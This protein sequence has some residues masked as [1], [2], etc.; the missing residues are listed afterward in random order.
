M[1]PGAHTPE[2]PFSPHTVEQRAMAFQVPLLEHVET[3]FPS[4][5][6]SL[7]AQMPVQAPLVQRY[8]QVAS[9]CM[10]PVALQTMRSCP[11]HSLAP[12]LHG[13]FTP[14]SVPDAASAPTPPSGFSRTGA[15]DPVSKSPITCTHPTETSKT[16]SAVTNQIRFR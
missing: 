8:G 9:D 5:F 6:I 1:A 12:E 10:T 11:L 4:H 14:E 15:S 16:A 2:Q 13:P 7:G 3:M